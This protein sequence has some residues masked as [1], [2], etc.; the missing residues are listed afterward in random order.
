MKIHEDDELVELLKKN[1]RDRCSQESLTKS[2]SDLKT[3]FETMFLTVNGLSKLRQVLIKR[4]IF[5]L[6]SKHEEEQELEKSLLNS[7]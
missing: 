6:I 3:F 4:E 7:L 1:I 5:S 2:P